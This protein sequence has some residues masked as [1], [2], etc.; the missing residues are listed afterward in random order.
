MVEKSAFTENSQSDDSWRPMNSVS[1]AYGDEVISDATS[2]EPLAG[3]VIAGVAI[4]G[5][6]T[7]IP[8][9]LSSYSVY[10]RLAL[11]TGAAD[12]LSAHHDHLVALAP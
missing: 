12:D 11:R 5:F 8:R 7:A 3:D 6:F 4:I 10:H 9:S 1:V 2:A